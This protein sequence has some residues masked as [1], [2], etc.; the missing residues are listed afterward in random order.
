MRLDCVLWSSWIAGVRTKRE[1]G[2]GKIGSNLKDWEPKG[3]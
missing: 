1:V 2:G 3:D